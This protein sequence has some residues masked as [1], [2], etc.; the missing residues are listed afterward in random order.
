MSAAAEKNGDEVP[1]IAAYHGAT[2]ADRDRREAAADGAALA[3]AAGLR[4]R[5]AAFE[6]SPTWKGIVEFA[7]EHD[8][9]LIVIG[10][11]GP[12]VRSTP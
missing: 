11:H 4:S 12:P 8:T 3:K 9:S 1:S 2:L 10:S 5:S 6:V 7:D